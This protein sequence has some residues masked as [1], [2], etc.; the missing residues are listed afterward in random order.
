MIEKQFTL[1]LQNRPGELAA[2]TKLLAD[3]KVNIDAMSVSA[4]TDVGLVQL[5]VSN[6]RQTKAVLNDAAIPYS[7]QDVAVVSMQNEPGALY[8]LVSKLARAKVNVSYVYATACSHNSDCM[9]RIVI[10]AP[11]L[12][13]VE[14][15]LG[16]KPAARKRAK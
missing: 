13:K 6:V 9:T 12:K 14:K 2:A 4:S 5:V 16:R 15:V 7:V 1:Y 8:K 10:S 11:E 3:A